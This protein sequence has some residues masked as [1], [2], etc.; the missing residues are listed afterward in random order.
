MAKKQQHPKDG[1]LKHVRESEGWTVNEL[2][3]QAGIAPATLRKAEE[4][5][6]VRPYVWG[7]ILKG[8]NT[9]PNKSRAYDIG[10]IRD[11]A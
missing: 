4:G 8:I 10:E 6:A 3:G 2:A 11:H 7:K 1:K 5:E 9:M